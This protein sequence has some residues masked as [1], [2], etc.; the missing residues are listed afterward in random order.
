MCPADRSVTGESMPYEVKIADD[1]SSVQKAIGQ[2]CMQ[3]TA[4]DSRAGGMWLFTRNAMIGQAV[5][6]YICREVIPV[7]TLSIHHVILAKDVGT[8]KIL[9]Q[10]DAEKLVIDQWHRPIQVPR[11]A[12]GN[13]E[14]SAQGRVV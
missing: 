10:G 9:D 11:H 5:F 1:L 7:H 13:I 8:M 6:D 3:V 4:A 12:G 2:V 14:V